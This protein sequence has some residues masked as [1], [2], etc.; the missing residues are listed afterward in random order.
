MEE[1]IGDDE[2]YINLKTFTF[3]SFV[4]IFFVKSSL[5]DLYDEYTIKLMCISD[6]KANL[7]QETV[8]MILDKYPSFFDGVNLHYSNK[9]EMYKLVIKAPTFYKLKN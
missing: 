6:N 3:L 4:N 9:D 1:E 2:E 7:T 8:S 5:L